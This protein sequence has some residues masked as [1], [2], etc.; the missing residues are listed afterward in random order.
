MYDIILFDFDGTIYDTIE[1]ITKCMQY[2]LKKHGIE[3]ELSK[4]CCFAGPPLAEKLPEVYGFN[5]E[6]TKSVIKDFRERYNSLGIYESRVFPEIPKLLDDLKKAGKRLGIATSK[7]QHMAEHLLEKEGII[8]YF[9]VIC[10]S[11]PDGGHG[12]KDEVIKAALEKFGVKD[13]SVVLV[14][15][16]KYDVIGAHKCNL[17]C[18]GVKYGYAAPGELDE[19]G[20]DIIAKDSGQ[21]LKIIID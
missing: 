11:Q 16:T 2:A 1:G 21:L 13:E 17:P 3:E 6:E 15:D 9:E 5:D 18:I 12:K 10:G 14:G 19:A 4:L 20:A 8:E 7:P